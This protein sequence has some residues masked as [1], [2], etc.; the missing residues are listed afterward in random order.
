M[1]D[2]TARCLNCTHPLLSGSFCPQCGQRQ[3]HRLT[4]G[5]VVHELVHVFTHADNTIVGYVPQLLFHPGRLVADYLAG[6]RK[7]Y[8]NPFQFLLLVVGLATAAAALLHYYE[9]TGAEMQRRFT[10]RMPA[11]Q[12]ARMVNYFNYLGKYYNVWWLLLA[13]PMYSFFTWLIYRNRKLNYAESFFVHV[14][15]GSAFNLYLALIWFVLWAMQYKVLA[16]T[17]VAPAVQVFVVLLYLS[18]IGRNG[19]GLSWAGASWRALL[20]VVL[21]AAG[22]YILNTIVFRWYVFGHLMR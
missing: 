14:V 8:F 10:G 2:S 16:T 20:T 21:S 6:R 7:R 17:S 4:V 19:L 3:P 12:L 13:L 9:A 1:S 11:D 22:S 15:V 5:H 18:L